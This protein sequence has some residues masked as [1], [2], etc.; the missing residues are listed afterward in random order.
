MDLLEIRKKK[1][2]SQMQMAAL[3]GVSIN[4]YINWERKVMNP[5]PEN[6]KKIKEA[7]GVK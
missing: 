4:T 5:N 7:L 3:I 6:E 1:G 2:L